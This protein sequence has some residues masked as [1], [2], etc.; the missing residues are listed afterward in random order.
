MVHAA[1]TARIQG[2]DL[3]SEQAT[4]IT[5]ALE[6]HAQYLG[7]APPPSPCS[8]PL[9]AVTPDPTWE[10]GYNEYANRLG[11]ALPNT[12]A[13][14]QIIRPTGA[15]HHMDWETLTHAEVGSVGLP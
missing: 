14:I 12:E 2:V 11:D 1:E 9:V 13:L 10:I 8:G 3:Y 4:R 7:S 5:A 15:D 6:L